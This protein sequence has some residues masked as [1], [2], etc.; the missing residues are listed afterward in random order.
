[1]PVCL[2]PLLIKTILIS[3]SPKANTK[4]SPSG[5]PYWESCDRLNWPPSYS[6]SVL[7]LGVNDDRTAPQNLFQGPADCLSSLWTEIELDQSSRQSLNFTGFFLVV[8][9]ISPASAPATAI[10][11]SLNTPISILLSQNTYSWD[12]ITAKSNGSDDTI[13]KLSINEITYSD[14]QLLSN[15]LPCCYAWIL[16]F[17]PNAW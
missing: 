1:M 6:V 14:W 9:I 5:L 7:T 10:F 15:N 4:N 3:S 2:S 13:P 12:C 17:L 8:P 11:K 16:N